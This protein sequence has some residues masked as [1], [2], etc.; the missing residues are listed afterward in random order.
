MLATLSLFWGLA[1]Y[2]IAVALR[3]FPPLT[4]VWLRLCF[5]SIA[6]YLLMHWQGGKLPAEWR[7]WLRF[8]LLSLCGNLLPFSLISWSETSISSSQAGLLMALMPISTVILAHFFVEHESLTTRRALGVGLGF[9]GVVV[10]IGPDALSRLGGPALLA[11]LAVVAATIA[12]AINAVYTKRLPPFNT[13]VVSTGSLIAGSVML[14]PVVMVIDRPWRLD[15]AIDAWIAAIA[16][17][18]FAT[19]LATWIYFKVVS[20]CGPG[21]LSIINYL[22]PVIAFAA[23]VAFLGEPAQAHQFLGVLVIFAGIALSQPRQQ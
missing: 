8:A 16:L 23:G 11:Q 22:I 19:G 5:G 13:L 14:L 6:V 3:G 15:P 9:L 2:Q 17:G 21:F 4:V 1:F 12:Y 7:W 18:I 20:D 10:L